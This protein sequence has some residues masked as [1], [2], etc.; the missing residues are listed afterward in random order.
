[1]PER[2]R[3][4]QCSFM[5]KV[6]FLFSAHTPQMNLGQTIQSMPQRVDIRSLSSAADT[7]GKN[8]YDIHFYALTPGDESSKIIVHELKIPSSNI[9]GRGDF[10]L[11]RRKSIH[12]QRP[13]EFSG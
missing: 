4:L 9:F 12:Q 5:D 10:Y 6:I 3:E 2:G 7:E 1:M 11:M 8:T 13:L